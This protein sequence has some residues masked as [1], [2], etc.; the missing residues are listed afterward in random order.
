MAGPVDE[1]TPGV[2]GRRQLR[3]GHADREQGISVLKAAFVQGMLDKPEF[4]LRVG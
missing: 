4:E 1:I 2:E 3:A